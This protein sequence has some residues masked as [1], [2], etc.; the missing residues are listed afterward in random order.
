MEV[1]DGDGNIFDTT[2]RVRDP[3]HSEKKVPTVTESLWG[4][5]EIIGSEKVEL[6]KKNPSD[7]IEIDK[8]LHK[9]DDIHVGTTLK[10]LNFR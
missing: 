2:D 9:Q 8:G 7:T 1:S 4:N 3:E 6:D 5:N 10:N